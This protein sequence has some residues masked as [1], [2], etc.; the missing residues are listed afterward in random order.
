MN[1]VRSIAMAAIAAI[2]F[3]VAVS[4]VAQQVSRQAA[5]NSEESPL[6]VWDLE[7]GAHAWELPS[8]AYAEFACGTRGGPPSL[9]LHEWGDYGLCPAE[10]ESGLHEVYFRHDDEL[11]YW[12]RAKNLETHIARYQG[13]IAFDIPIIVSGLFDGDGF[14]LG[15]RIVSDPRTDV[16][17][18]EK[19]VLLGDSLASRYSDEG[20]ACEEFPP[21]EGQQAYHGDFINRQCSKVE[22]ET[23]LSLFLEMRY[24][25]K[26]GQQAIGRD[27]LRT[28][29]EFESTT[30]FEAALL[31]GIPDRNERLAALAPPGPSEKSLRIER[32][33]DCPGCD[34]H[35]ADFKRADLSGAN[36]AGADLSG[37]N[38]HGAI[39]QGANLEGA[40]LSMANLNR[41]DAKRARF[42]GAVLRKAMMYGAR[43]NSADLSDTDLRNALARTAQLI[44]ADLSGATAV[45]MD[46]REGRLNDA[47]FSGADF[48]WSWFH[49]AQLARANLA[50]V[51]LSNTRMWNVSMV[52]VN[53]SGADVRDA[54]LFG[55]NLRGAD[56]SRANFTGANLSRT[57]LTDVV[58]T[59]A[60]FDRAKLPPGVTLH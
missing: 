11:E 20:W 53:L 19:G 39:L 3:L 52:N 17:T 54:D 8:E 13:T 1:S 59:G 2:A 44:R 51:N 7:L 32:A 23:N 26:S 49:D 40:D 33:H 12:A 21:L 22:Q 31:G 4:A 5:A 46:L 58:A 15:I 24:M 6:T 41:V 9:P 38:L 30:V 37:A 43:L 56:L 16:V 55:A 48:S 10:P 18:R 57:V 29:G 35:G 28:A 34:F 50:N 25:R 14:L 47:D 60:N 45:A 27:R 36:L 42:K